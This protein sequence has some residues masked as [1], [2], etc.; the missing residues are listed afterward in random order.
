M[1][2]V[3]SKGPGVK[4]VESVTSVLIAPPAKKVNLFPISYN[5]VTIALKRPVLGLDSL[6][7]GLGDLGPSESAGVKAKYVDGALVPIVVTRAIACQK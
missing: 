1:R 4:A 7:I 3:P 6:A 2:C 5:S